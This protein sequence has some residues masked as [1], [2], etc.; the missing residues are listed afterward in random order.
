MWSP[1]N[2]GN[3]LYKPSDIKGIELE[4]VAEFMAP[5]LHFRNGVYSAVQEEQGILGVGGVHLRDRNASN[6]VRWLELES[7]LCLT[8]LHLPCGSGEH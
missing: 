6:A 5:S 4:L 3:V 7:H 8:K 2:P 1:G